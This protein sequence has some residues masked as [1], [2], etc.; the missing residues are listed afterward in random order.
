MRQVTLEELLE[1]FVNTL[2]DTRA[3]LRILLDHLDHPLDFGLQRLTADVAGI[4]TKR[5]RPHVVDQPPGRMIQPVEKIRF[6][7]SHAQHRHLQPGKPDPDPGRN[8]VFLQNR[9]EHEGDELNDGLFV[10]VLRQILEFCRLLLQL[11]SQS[12]QQHRTKLRRTSP[13]QGVIRHGALR[14]RCHQTL[15]R[16]LPKDCC[17]I[18]G[19]QHTGH[20]ATDAV[21]QP[22]VTRTG[23]GWRDSSSRRRRPARIVV[24]GRA[25]METRR[26]PPLGG[27]ARQRAPAWSCPL[28]ILTRH[29][30]VLWIIGRRG[31]LL[32]GFGARFERDHRQ[33]TLRHQLGIAVGIDLSP[34][35]VDMVLHHL[36]DQSPRLQRHA[37]SHPLLHQGL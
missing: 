17:E 32:P 15:R 27:T 29:V 21:Q 16:N 28:L 10:V 9:L 26:R 25:R 19:R 36:V 14:Q 24:C 33:H 8:P 23:P 7:Q 3:G 12:L 30:V 4:K 34:L 6:G 1:L 5:A 18:L 2:V 31:G 35:R 22:H 20:H 37:A 11:T 13:S